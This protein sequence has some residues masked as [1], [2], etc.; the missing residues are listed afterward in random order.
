MPKLFL[1]PPP[2]IREVLPTPP[3][4]PVLLDFRRRR[5]ARVGIFTVRKKD[6][7]Q[8]LILDARQANACHRAPPTTRLSTP[9][10]L[11]AL[12]LSAQTLIADGFGSILGEDAPIVTAESGD[13][14]DCF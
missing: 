12:D 7:A 4:V 6:G 1:Y 14:G 5:K 9:A 8:R 13:V 10:S 11:A 3:P 2:P